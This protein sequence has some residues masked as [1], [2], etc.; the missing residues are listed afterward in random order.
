MGLV[1]MPYYGA[2]SG[3]EDLPEG[4]REA[5]PPE[6][7]EGLDHTSHPIAILG[8]CMRVPLRWCCNMLGCAASAGCSI[9]YLGDRHKRVGLRLRAYDRM[10]RHAVLALWTLSCRAIIPPCLKKT[11]KLCALQ[12][13]AADNEPIP[14]NKVRCR[15]RGK[16]LHDSVFSLRRLQR[17]VPNCRSSRSFRL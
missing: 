2:L 3:T 16:E 1:N 11:L 17:V 5:P 4:R 14:R 10:Q 13:P 12:D 8:S 9:A 15:N 6:G 7:E